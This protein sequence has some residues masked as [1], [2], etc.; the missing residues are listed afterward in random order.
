MKPLRLELAAFGA[1]AKPCVI[2]FERIDHGLFLLTGPTGSG[3]TTLFD[4]IKFALYGEM[5]GSV[6]ESKSIRSGFAE[7]DQV[8]YVELEFEHQGS[9]Y[10]IHRAPGGYKWRGKKKNRTELVMASEDVWLRNLTTGESLA[11][12]SRAATE[13]IEELLGINAHQFSRIVMIAQ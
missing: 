11:G 4:A 2:D 5:S 8:T 9:R 3:K 7:E 10:A 1:Y 12:K 13:Y 6:R